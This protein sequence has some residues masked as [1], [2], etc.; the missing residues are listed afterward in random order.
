MVLVMLAFT[1]AIPAHRSVGNVKKL[2]PPATELSAP[3][4]RAET[5]SRQIC[6]IFIITVLYPWLRVEIPEIKI[7]RV[8]GLP[9]RLI[10][11]VGVE[12][13]D[14][15]IDSYLSPLTTA[16]G[17]GLAKLPPQLSIGSL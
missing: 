3:P 14:L 7:E 8:G 2:P 5:K 10:R 15:E 12:S 9:P 16:K 11:P 17:D 6:N 13:L 4:N 1:G